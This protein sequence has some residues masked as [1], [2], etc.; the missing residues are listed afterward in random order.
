MHAV[1]WIEADYIK[2]TSGNI[3]AHTWS[4]E[5]HTHEIRSA[6]LFLDTVMGHKNIVCEKEMKEV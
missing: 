2:L 4:V 5:L 1:E 3:L 6:V